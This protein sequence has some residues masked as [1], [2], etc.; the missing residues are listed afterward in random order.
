MP[1]LTAPRRFWAGVSM[2][3]LLIGIT[4]GSFI[5]GASLT[6]LLAHLREIRS[7]TSQNRLMQDLRTATDLMARDLRR[8]GYWGAAGMGVWQAAGTSSP[9]SAPTNPYTAV[10]TSSTSVTFRYSRD[11]TENNVVDSNEQFS[12][13]LRNGVLEL[14]LGNA[15]WQAMTD[16]TTMKVTRFSITPAEDRHSLA[17]SCAT[18]CSGADLSCPPQLLVRSLVVTLGAQSTEDRAIEHS[19]HTRVHLPNDT[20]TGR[21]PA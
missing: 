20:V 16:A 17:G 5:V 15:P 21:C 2:V 3:E 11:A 18:P 13:R 14:Q 7:L 12:Y 10:A 4:I 9:A 6:T 1:P 8:V 19:L